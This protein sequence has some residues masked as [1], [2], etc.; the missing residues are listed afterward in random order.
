MNRGIRK[1][2]HK[3]LVAI[4]VVAAT[5]G[6]SGRAFGDAGKGETDAANQRDVACPS[7]WE[8]AFER[9]RSASAWIETPF[10]NGNGLLLTSNVVAAPSSLVVLDYGTIRVRLPDETITDA[11]V[12][13]VDEDKGLAL[14]QLQQSATFLQY[15]VGDPAMLPLFAP[16][17]SVR[18]PN[19]AFDSPL[20]P[21]RRHAPL[22][23]VRGN[24]FSDSTFGLGEGETPASGAAV[25]GCDARI[26]GLVLQRA[27]EPPRLLPP[28]AL[29]D[30]LA[31][32]EHHPF[33]GRSPTWGG[34]LFVGVTAGPSANFGIATAFDVLRW[35]RAHLV[36]TVGTVFSKHK[37]G[38]FGDLALGARWPFARS[39]LLVDT[40]LGGGVAATELK[41]NGTPCVQ[42]GCQP[43]RV[44]SRGYV[45]GRL[46]VNVGVFA[47]GYTLRVN[48]TY[49]FASHVLSFGL[50]YTPEFRTAMQNR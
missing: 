31:A 4:T 32:A 48:P 11:E 6:G 13:Y 19:T 40:E 2:A 10:G 44:A 17:L 14:L 24:R 39:L 35:R 37:S 22:R 5:I 38:T 9:A 7:G 46:Q 23:V 42:E 27:G 25:F 41:A 30:A 45:L 15:R 1:G 20:S 33:L 8:S 34:G 3:L 21:I 29:E 28:R 50:G 12:I 26:Y 16:L 47:L 18:Q 43:A 36:G 49:G